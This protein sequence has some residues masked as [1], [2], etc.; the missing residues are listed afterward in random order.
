MQD[1]YNC[2]HVFHQDC[3]SNFVS[4]EKSKGNIILLECPYP[5]CGKTVTK[6]DVESLLNLSQQLAKRNFTYNF[7]CC[8][9]ADCPYVYEVPKNQN[10]KN[11]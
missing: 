9:T 7:A 6:P 5:K 4:K 3:L 2:K 10:A 8:P 1:L 11:Y